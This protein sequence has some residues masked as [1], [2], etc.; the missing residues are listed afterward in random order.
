MAEEISTDNQSRKSEIVTEDST[1]ADVLQVVERLG[2]K[3]VDAFNEASVRK[4]RLAN[5]TIS[6]DKS[7]LLVFS[8]ALLGTLSFAFYLILIDKLD[9]V[10]N[11]L[12]PVISLVLG[13][14]S[15]YFAGSGRTQ[16]KR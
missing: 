5:A 11:F 16:G 2:N 3:V 7:I 8:I 12:Y 15:G 14:M 9:P 1:E 6:I 4:D 13:F 10:A